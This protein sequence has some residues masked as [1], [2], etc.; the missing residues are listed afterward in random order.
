MHGSSDKRTILLSEPIEVAI[1][2]ILPPSGSAPRF[3]PHQNWGYNEAQ[4]IRIS[5]IG[6]SFCLFYALIAARAC[7]DY[8][9]RKMA[10]SDGSDNNGELLGLHNV[11]GRGDFCADYEALN[12]LLSNQDKMRREVRK[13]M[14][15]AEIDEQQESYGMEH[16][17]AIQELWVC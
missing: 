7:H 8:E 3:F 5:N 17:A 1:T 14:R 6:D 16:I 12:R 2:C 11:I 15:S 13:L 4:R 10:A 9:I